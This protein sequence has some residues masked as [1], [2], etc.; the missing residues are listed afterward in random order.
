MILKTKFPLIVSLLILGF[1]VPSLFSQGADPNE[2]IFLPFPEKLKL[3]GT[4]ANEATSSNPNSSDLNS[5]VSS[6]VVGT[7]KETTANTQTSTIASVKNSTSGSTTSSGS[8]TS[9]KPKK[10]K[11]GK[12]D[13]PDP[14][15]APFQRGKAFLARNQK[16]NAETEF[17]ESY[18]KEGKKVDPSLTENTN[19]FGLD[20]KEK[21]GTGLV[22][23][24]ENPDAKIKSQFE[25]ARSL[26][27]MNQ[28]E[29]EEKAYK[30]Y[31]K[32][33]TSFPVHPE[34]TPRTHLAIAALL[35]R[36]QEYR[37]ALH[38]LVK[39]IKE[40]KD[41]KDRPTAYYYAGRIY[42][43]AWAERDLERAKKYYDLYLKESED[44]ELSPGN[45]FRKEAKERRR[46]IEAPL[47]I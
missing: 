18:S 35:F 32:L 1:F 14:S 41:S 28:P 27:R 9:A 13:V 3:D 26:D 36:K 43:S 11:K 20:S 29:S 47:G 15:E 38:H 44:K 46:L 34:L 21:E 39:L 8:E 40:F 30:E 37:P 25:L 31:L 24:I 23:K 19:L 4:E 16:K 42:E 22:E 33:V 5:S 2:E 17:S 10:K 6:T 7:G 12:D 45:D